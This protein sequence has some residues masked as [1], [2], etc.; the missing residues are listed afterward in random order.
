MK[1]IQLSDVFFNAECR[2][3]CRRVPLRMLMNTN[4]L[5][6]SLRI[7]SGSM[8]LKFGIFVMII[9][10]AC[11]RPAGETGEIAVDARVPVTVASTGTGEMADYLELSATS[12]FQIKSVVK[13]PATGYIDE[14]LVTPGDAVI[15]SKELFRIRTK[16]SAAL[17]G[18]TTNPLA[19]SGLIPVRASLNGMVTSIDHPKGDY[20]QEGDQIA[21]ITVPSSL[22]FILEVPFESGGFIKTG[23]SCEVILPDG[24]IVAGQVKSML[25]AMTNSSQTQRFIIQP[26]TLR[27]EPENLIA[28][29]RIVKKIT[30][31]AISLPKSCILS[32]EMQQNFWVMKLIN[33]SM[34]VIVAVKPGLHTADRIE[35]TEPA[36][37]STDRFLA[38]GNYGLGD[39]AKVIIQGILKNQ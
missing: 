26:N 30:P 28:R 21:M 36:F 6:G 25:P 1:Q 35:I 7:L 37:S 38:S 17:R 14:Q 32:D 11:H 27:H 2:R 3:V 33:D 15:K 8:R 23:A 34:A 22:V 12:A 10:M 31:K 16:E 20:V 18:D 5:C 24:Q 29:V 9:L 39:T 19:F 4:I 13:S